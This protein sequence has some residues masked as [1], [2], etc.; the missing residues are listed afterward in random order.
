MSKKKKNL[1]LIINKLIKEQQKKLFKEG[2]YDD[3]D[4]DTG[5]GGGGGPIAGC[6]DDTASNYNPLA[7][8]PCGYDYGVSMYNYC[9][10][11]P[12]W[13]CTQPGADNYQPSA[14]N[15]DGSCIFSDDSIEVDDDDMT[16]QGE[17]NPSAAVVQMGQVGSTM[18]GYDAVWRIKPGSITINYDATY[19]TQQAA[20]NYNGSSCDSTPWQ[21]IPPN[22]GGDGPDG[23]VVDPNT[24][25]PTSY[26]GDEG[27]KLPMI[28][29]KESLNNRIKKLLKK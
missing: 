25:S 17:I 8:L 13:G 2:P 20:D 15:D 10:Q 29:L 11:Y 19:A 27:N 14:T 9:C 6:T 4:K 26:K 24:G 18:G 7:D 12:V 23:I 5:G 3:I 22:S 28:G 21:G 16:W 1:K